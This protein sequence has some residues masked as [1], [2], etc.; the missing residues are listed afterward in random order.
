MVYQ[1]G[2]SVKADDYKN[3]IS[4]VN[5]V[6][7]TGGINPSTLVVDGSYGYGGN[8]INSPQDNLDI[9][10]APLDPVTSNDWKELLGA[11][12]DCA[13]HQGTT[14]L[15]QLPVSSDMDTG[16]TIRAGSNASDPYYFQNLD[17]TVA[18][19]N[20]NDLITN[21]LTF[22]SANFSISL[23]VLP[24]QI[25]TSWMSQIVHEFTVTFTTVDEARFFFNTGGQIIISASRS[26]GTSN[27]LNDDWTNFL[28]ANGPAIL[29]HGI[30]PPAL[31][32]GYYDLT[33]DY[34]DVE[35]LNVSS[36]APFTV[37]NWMVH[38]KR[39]DAAPFANGGNGRIIKIRSQFNNVYGGTVDGTFDSL[40]NERKSTAIFNN[41]ASPIYATTNLTS[42]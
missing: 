6:F 4:K 9:N 40:I 41:V 10:K 31:T 17:P 20:I 32:K 1:T 3:L 29:D 42:V 12:T 23:D 26:P 35:L 37:N 36:G 13:D 16:D 25:T 34:V 2:N 39:V 30:M 18:V 19:N 33:M 8:S 27:A 28:S 11:Y 7:G 5:G 38:A 21:H 15:D 22:N 14:L 24:T